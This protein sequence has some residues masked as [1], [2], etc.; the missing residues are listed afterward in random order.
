MLCVLCSVALAIDDSLE[1]TLSIQSMRTR[2]QLHRW[3]E[4]KLFLSNRPG[5]NK[6]R[7]RWNLCISIPELDHRKTD[8]YCVGRIESHIALLIRLLCSKRRMLEGFPKKLT[9]YS[10]RF[11][12]VVFVLKTVCQLKLFRQNTGGR[13]HNLLDFTVKPFPVLSEWAHFAAP[14]LAVCQPFPFV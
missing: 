4:Y 8:Q 14:V 2:E 13:S 5:S 3:M 1:T 11:T 7:W 9:D 6:I 12:T 10:L